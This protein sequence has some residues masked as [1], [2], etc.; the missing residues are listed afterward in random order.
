[1]QK[2]LVRNLM[3]I[4]GLEEGMCECVKCISSCGVKGGNGEF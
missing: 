1:M 2:N 3:L 4:L